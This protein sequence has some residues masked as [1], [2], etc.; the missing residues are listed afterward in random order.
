MMILWNC[1][2]LQMIK[3]VLTKKNLARKNEM[4][5]FVRICLRK[6]NIGNI[7]RPTLNGVYILY[8]K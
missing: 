5:Y 6:K 4:K 3:L 2:L 7:K 8:I 1:Q